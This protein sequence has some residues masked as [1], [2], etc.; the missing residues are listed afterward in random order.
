MRTPW[1]ISSLMLVLLVAFRCLGAAFPLELANFSPLPALFLCAVIALRGASCWIVPVVAWVLSAPIAN[2]MQGYP[3]FAHFGSTLIP[4]ATLAV[5]AL[6]ARPLRG[7]LGPAGLLGAGLVAALLFHLVTNGIAWLADPRY[8]KTATGL[9]QSLWTGLP[10][11]PLPSWVFLR[12]LAVANL[13]FTALL[14]LARPLPS[15]P[16]RD[17]LA[18]G[19]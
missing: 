4:L 16:W 6:A 18:A 2:L 1:L 14:L 12:N 10:G 8:A 5:I 19:R 17:A 9:V 7:K 13:V 3:A 11:D 15:S